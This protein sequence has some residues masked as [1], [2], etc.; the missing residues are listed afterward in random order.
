[1]EYEDA[2]HGF[3]PEVMQRALAE[4]VEWFNAHLEPN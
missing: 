2:G 3:P 4:M 1:V